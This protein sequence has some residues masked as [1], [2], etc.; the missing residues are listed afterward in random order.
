MWHAPVRPHRPHPPPTGRHRAQNLE[1]RMRAAPTAA[2]VILTLATQAS[3]QETIVSLPHVG[4]FT[5]GPRAQ[6]YP[7]NTQD[8]WVIEDFTTT[9]DWLLGH[10]TV[11]GNGFGT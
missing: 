8:L 1:A 5:A 10:F 9:S 3:A 6:D 7:D 2:V 11:Y 4:S